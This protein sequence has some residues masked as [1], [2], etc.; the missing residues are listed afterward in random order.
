MT[1]TLTK[2]GQRLVDLEFQPGDLPLAEAPSAALPLPVAP[3]PV[4][5]RIGRWSWLALA[6]GT[7]V[8]GTVVVGS[9]V[10]FARRALETGSLYDGA[11]LV[12]TSALVISI[13]ALV[14]QQTRA[15]RRLKSAE[16]ARALAQELARLD[17]AGHG[18]ALLDS[19]RAIYADNPVVLG[20]LAAAGEALQA[21]HSDHD[22]LAH[23]NREIFEPMD[24]AADARV[25]QAALRATIGVSACPHPALD[26]LVVLGVSVVLVRDLMSIYGLRHSARSLLRVMTRAVFDSSATAALST[27]VEFLA[28]AAQDRLAA[29]IAGTA[30]EALIVA[31][32]MLRLGDL[33]KAEIRPLPPPPPAA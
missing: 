15:F 21:H 17:G 28:N 33:A 10:G 11:L 12:G 16:R 14:A 31:R 7:L 13:A 23:L 1:T 8:L 5:R 22:V 6:S 19:L 2:D 20:Q 4:H 9:I 24:R 29:T 32:R 30:G 25:R 3:P 18:A 26:A 27:A